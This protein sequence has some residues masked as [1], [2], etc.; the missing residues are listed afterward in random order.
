M[1]PFLREARWL[2]APA[3]GLSFLLL[4]LFWL[5]VAS[6]SWKAGS[7][8]R[9]LRWTGIFAGVFLLLTGNSLVHPAKHRLFFDEDVYANMAANLLAGDGPNVTTGLPP[10]VSAHKWPAGFPTVAAVGVALKGVERGPIVVNGALAIFTMLLC[11]VAMVRLAGS[12]G[13]ALGAVAT[14]F[15]HPLVGPWYRAG[16]SEPLALLLLL[17]SWVALLLLEEAPEADVPGWAAIALLSGFLAPL[18]RLEFIAA[19]PFLV[20]WAWRF[21]PWRSLLGIWGFTLS[22]V[23][24][25]L[26][27]IHAT[28]L[29]SYYWANRPES[30]FGLSYV[31]PNAY[32]NAAFLAKSGSLFLLVPAVVVFACLRLRRR[33]EP[34]RLRALGRVWILAL[35]QVAVLLPYSAGAYVLPGGTRFLIPIV[36]VAAATLGL[37]SYCWAT[38]TPILKAAV[39]LTSLGLSLAAVPRTTSIFAKTDSPAREHAWVVDTAARLAPESLVISTAPYLWANQGRLSSSNLGDGLAVLA[40]RPVYVHE[41]L[42]PSNWQRHAY[43]GQ[44]VSAFHTQDGAVG[45]FRLHSGGSSSAEERP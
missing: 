32:S 45:L 31:L 12:T 14:F 42:L 9:T 22:A 5:R 18:V 23:L 40:E 16:S 37:A 34:R 4:V 10:Q 28:N 17:S 38:P 7:M 44:L 2:Q 25:V 11:S 39:A 1:A 8:A 6:R 36:L 26:F 3:F 35:V 15:L 24:L 20:A 27:A 30:S 19:T 13:L 43:D 41:G 33:A 21:H 29:P